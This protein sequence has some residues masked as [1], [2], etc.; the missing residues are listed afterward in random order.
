MSII[1]QTHNQINSISKTAQT[2]PVTLHLTIQEQ[3]LAISGSRLKCS[4]SRRRL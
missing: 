1:L 3:D 4:R 2:M